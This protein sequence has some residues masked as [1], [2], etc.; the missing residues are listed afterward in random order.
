MIS[1]LSTKLLSSS[2]RGMLSKDRFEVRE[3]N[4][5][6]IIPIHFALP[7]VLNNVIFTS[8][9]T[10]KIFLKTAQREEMDLSPIKAFCVGVKT[11]GLLEENGIEV[12]AYKSYAAD[13]VEVIKNDF[14]EL[15]FDFFCGNI[16]RDTIP[17][18][19]LNAGISFTETAV[20]KTQLNFQ[21]WEQ[22]FDAVL[23]YSPSEVRS[24]FKKNELERNAIA[25]CIGK[26]TAEE[27]EKHVS[28]VNISSDT[29]I[30]SVLEKTRELL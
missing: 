5:I 29:T 3:Y 14:S 22:T 4:A 12:I 30:E 16:R 28:K 17:D 24:Y 20:Y 2:Q 18:G 8:Q 19:L 9:H 7:N 10:V 15:H 21:E 6:Q 1:V 25:I 27:A 11:A 13:L 23:F 26:T